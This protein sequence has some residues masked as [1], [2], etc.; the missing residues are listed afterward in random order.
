MDDQKLNSTNAPEAD[1]QPNSSGQ[2]LAASGQVMDVT[3]PQSVI[4]PTNTVGGNIA[5]TDASSSAETTPTIS[6]DPT[7]IS[8]PAPTPSFHFSKRL[9]YPFVTSVK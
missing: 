7:P 6:S 5:V 8:E 4:E 1:I 2:G 3:A 9:F